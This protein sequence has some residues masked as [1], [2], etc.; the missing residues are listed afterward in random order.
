MSGNN[1]KIKK[2]ISIGGKTFVFNM[3]NHIKHDGSSTGYDIALDEIAKFILNSATSFYNDLTNPIWYLS[4]GFRICPIYSN[5]VLWGFLDQRSQQTNPNWL[6][7]QHHPLNSSTINVTHFGP[8]G[9]VNNK[10]YG[11]DWNRFWHQFQNDAKVLNFRMLLGNNP[12]KAQIQQAEAILR[13]HI[14]ANYIKLMEILS[15]DIAKAKATLIDIV[16]VVFGATADAATITA[17]LG[18]ALAPSA[19]KIGGKV[20]LKE[21]LVT[22]SKQIAKEIAVISSKTAAKGSGKVIGTKIPGVGLGIGAIFG[23]YR[24]CKGD[25]VGAC[26]ELASG[27]ASTVP[28]VGTAVSFAIDGA[29]ACKDVVEALAELK[30]YQSCI[31]SLES[32]L[33]K[34]FDQINELERNHEL[35]MNTFFQ[36]GFDFESNGAQFVE[37]F[38]ILMKT[39]IAC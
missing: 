25:F 12:S 3:T 34:L 39:V 33:G 8:F 32:E 26:G 11:N 22:I 24:V 1:P 30:H 17:N 16:K 7:F 13:A 4:N 23:M 5:N 14:T 2:T 15:S 10:N 28:G 35:I 31:E 6:I 18:V 20:L 36:D 27:V 19:I 37:A 38:F 29:L 21:A 9:F